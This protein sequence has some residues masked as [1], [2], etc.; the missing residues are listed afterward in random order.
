MKYLSPVIQNDLIEVFAN[1][2]KHKIASDITSAPF[3]VNHYHGYDIGCVNDKST[4]LGLPV[5]KNCSSGCGSYAA[6]EMCENSLGF[7][8]NTDQ[9]EAGIYNQISKSLKA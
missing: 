9:I 4:Q 5:C 6:L 2:R 1:Q 7:D 8:A 3:F